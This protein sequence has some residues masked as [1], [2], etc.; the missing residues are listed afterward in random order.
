MFDVCGG[1]QC[2]S[3][4]VGFRRVWW[5]ALDSTR[6]ASVS[7][8]IRRGLYMGMELT[9]G[10]QECMVYPKEPVGV[11]RVQLFRRHTVHVGGRSFGFR[12]DAPGVFCHPVLR[13]CELCYESCKWLGLGMGSFEGGLE[14]F[15]GRGV[16]TYPLGVLILCGE[17][18]T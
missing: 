11:R 7:V 5:I 10:F 6:V 15:L 9:T 14:G 17:L 13:A 2:P 1:D 12:R 18:T 16:V 4:S 8:G 3:E